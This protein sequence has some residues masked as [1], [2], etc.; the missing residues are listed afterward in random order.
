MDESKIFNKIATLETH[1]INICHMLQNIPFLTER[2][3]KPLTLDSGDLPKMITQIRQI[4]IKLCNNLQAYDLKQTFGEIQYIGKRLKQI[5]A[6]IS[7]LKKEGLKRKIDLDFCVNGYEMVKKKPENDSISPESALQRVLMSL[8]GR[9]QEVLKH[10]YGLMGVKSKTL[11]K[12]GKELGVSR[13]RIRQIQQTALKKLRHP[14]RHSLVQD[15]TQKKLREDI[16]LEDGL[17]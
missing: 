17:L 3:N 12:A 15:L 13:E 8:S 6:D 9:E 7:D 5:E 16:G 14:S 4:M 2:L 11:E 10:L 1:I